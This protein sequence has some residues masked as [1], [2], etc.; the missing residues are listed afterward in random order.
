MLLDELP[1]VLVVHIVGFLGPV[2][3]FR[4]DVEWREPATHGTVDTTFAGVPAVCRALSFVR[5]CAQ[6]Y[7]AA[8][9]NAVANP[10]STAPRTALANSGLWR[11]M[12]KSAVVE[13]PFCTV[14]VPLPRMLN[15]E[16]QTQTEV[17]Q[18]QCACMDAKLT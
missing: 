12:L 17:G 4:D 5:T 1:Q 11:A 2:R 16:D 8:F 13:A 6:V 3:R 10:C 9:K 15:R 18:L 7:W 14:E